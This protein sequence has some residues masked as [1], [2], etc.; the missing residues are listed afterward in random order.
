MVELEGTAHCR[1]MY[2]P[3]AL[4]HAGVADTPSVKWAH[5]T[6]GRNV[7]DYLSK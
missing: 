1:D 6:I 3:G 7:A 5:A 4:E 2:A